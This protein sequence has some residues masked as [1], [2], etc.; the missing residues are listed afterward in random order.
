M[1]SN[2]IKNLFFPIFRQCAYWVSL[3][4]DAVGGWGI[5]VAAFL[6]VCIVGMFLVPL[7]GGAISNI[8]SFTVN[9]IYSGRSNS[10]EI[11]LDSI[12]SNPSGSKPRRYL[13]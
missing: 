3:L 8:S 11:K 9:K 12:H 1:V 10:K 13:G 6:I 2:I 7:R 4:F 5:Y